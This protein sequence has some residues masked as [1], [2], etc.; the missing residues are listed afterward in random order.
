ME[1]SA[2]NGFN[3]ENMFCEAAKLL[4]EEYQQEKSSQMD[5][6]VK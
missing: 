2:K 3:V 4:Y 1:T 5:S 6:K